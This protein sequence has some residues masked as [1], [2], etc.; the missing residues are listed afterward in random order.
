MRYSK[1]KTRTIAAASVA[2]ALIAAACSSGGDDSGAATVAPASV[3]TMV[4]TPSVTA[5]PS[6]TTAA[7]TETVAEAQDL[8]SVPESEGS[9][10]ADAVEPE[11]SASDVASAAP[12]SGSAP[13]ETSEPPS[14]TTTTTTTAEPSVSSETETAEIPGTTLPAPAEI[15]EIVVLP[16]EIEAPRSLQVRVLNASG[17]AG[18]AGALT[19][20]LAGEGYVMLAPGNAPR[21][22]A[23]SAVYFAEG[24]RDEALEILEDT[25]IEQIEQPLPLPQQ[26]AE[27][28]AAVIVLLGTDTAPAVSAEQTQLRPEQRNNTSLP[29]PASTPRDRYV[30]G[31]AAA[32]IYTEANENNPASAGQ[33]ADLASFLKEIGDCSQHQ[34]GTAQPDRCQNR[35]PLSRLY[36]AVEDLLT[37]LGFTPQNVCGAPPGYSFTG[38]LQ[39]TREMDSEWRYY[40][41]DAIF[42]TDRLIELHGGE[43]I[44]PSENLSFYIRQA[45][46]TAHDALRLPELLD[47]TEAPQLI[48]CRAWLAPS[49]EIPEFANGAWYALLTPGIQPRESLLSQGTYHVK[50]IS[51][52]G[53]YAYVLVCHPTVGS[54]GIRLYWRETGYRAEILEGPNREGCQRHFEQY[55]YIRDDTDLG[56]TREDTLTFGFGERA[57]STSDLQA[58]PRAG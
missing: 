13:P 54:N 26:L 1:M 6:I 42:T 51:R 38:L 47:E 23:S 32:N 12:S 39:P 27:P 34:L 41:G 31:L 28:E 52:N 50:E 11:D 15:P 33:L 48:L 2:V 7:P 49:S 25:G 3:T 20:R 4:E 22:Y 10:P 17:V 30:P 58:F 43:R 55:P 56:E 45:V 21:R 8:P 46:Q 29:L 35:L 57:F 16:G 14:S 37:D 44:N 53:N 24:W 36:Q 5:S 19:G 9:L 18:A 40:S